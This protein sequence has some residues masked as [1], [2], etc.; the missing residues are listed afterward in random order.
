M[1]GSQLNG[2]QWTASAATSCLED[3]EAVTHKDGGTAQRFVN[4]S[5]P[6]RHL[7][8]SLMFSYHC[9]QTMHFT[10]SSGM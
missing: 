5:R 6:E 9:A 8:A 2:V 3:V 4:V 1:D 7:K 10:T